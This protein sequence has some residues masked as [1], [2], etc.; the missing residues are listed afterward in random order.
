MHTA[1][2]RC[3]KLVEHFNKSTKETYR[4]R[5]KQ[6]ML[7]LEEHKLIQDCPTRWGSTLLM[8]QHVSEQQAAIVA[9][10]IEGKVQYLMPEGEEWNIIDNLINILEP[11]QKITEVISNEK[12]PTISSVRPL[13]YKLLEKTLK[14][15]SDDNATTKAMKEAVSKDLSNRYQTDTLKNVVNVTAILDPRYKE[16]PF[17]SSAESKEIFDYLEQLLIDMH[18]SCDSEESLEVASGERNEEQSSPIESPAKR[19]RNSEDDG[20]KSKFAKLL[21]DIFETDMMPPRLALVDKVR[22]EISLY[23][24]EHVAD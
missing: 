6:K 1:I 8:L 22:R 19:P 5:E 10:L 11:F 17:L 14:I 13:L 15:T 24:A 3:K 16:L 20:D 21:S 18:L 2:A 7:Q 4:L 23:K 9:V 12:F